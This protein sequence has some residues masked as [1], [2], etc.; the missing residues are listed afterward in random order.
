MTFRTFTT[1][2]K[3]SEVERLIEQQRSAGS[4]NEVLIEIAKDLRGRL[5][6]A[7]S[8]ALLQLERRLAATQHR[9]FEPVRSQIDAVVGVGEELIARWPIVKQA[10]ERFGAELEVKVDA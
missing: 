3:L 2:E 6:G 8:V 1:H 5:A 9:R 7:P 4:R 10:L